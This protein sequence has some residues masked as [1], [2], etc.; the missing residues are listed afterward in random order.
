MSI[1]FTRRRFV[2][3]LAAMPAVVV[4]RKHF[5]MPKM[6][7]AD[8]LRS[9]GWVIDDHRFESITD[10]AADQSWTVGFGPVPTKL[11]VDGYFDQGYF[12][13][14]GNARVPFWFDGPVKVVAALH[15]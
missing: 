12:V 13:H 1:D 8:R 10:G 14:D 5:V 15:A 4:A 9:H 2:F 11:L 6:S 3:G 7:A